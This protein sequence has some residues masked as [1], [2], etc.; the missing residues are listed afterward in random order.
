MTPSEI[1]TLFIGLF[2]A[3]W[4]IQLAD[5]TGINMRTIQRWSANGVEDDTINR[6]LSQLNISDARRQMIWPRDEWL[7]SRRIIEDEDLVADETIRYYIIHTLYPAFIARVIKLDTDLK[8][9]S[10]EGAVDMLNGIIHVSPSQHL[11]LCEIKWIDQPSHREAEMTA[12]FERAAIIYCD[13]AMKM[14]R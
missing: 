14:E 9:I 4:K 8:P 3:N 1:K 12:L 13:D 10:D 2:G 7:F 6:I 11:M 5:K